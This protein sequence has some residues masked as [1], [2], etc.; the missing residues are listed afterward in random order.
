MKLTLNKE[1]H[2]EIQFCVRQ[3][4]Q[5]SLQIRPWRKKLE[6]R[7]SKKNEILVIEK[8]NFL[9]KKHHPPYLLETL[10]PPP[11]IKQEALHTSF[12]PSRSLCRPFCGLY[13][14]NARNLIF[15][16][17]KIFDFSNFGQILIWSYE[18]A[19]FCTLN[20]NPASKPA[21]TKLKTR[22]L[23]KIRFL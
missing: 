12:S 18:S 5:K 4:P 1:S 16:N 7:H 21:Q 6:I 23:S 20:K 13:G 3:E 8:T 19:W 11:R 14:P 2:N 9:V 15:C 22:F 17:L 10:S